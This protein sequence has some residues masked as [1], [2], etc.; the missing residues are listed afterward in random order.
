MH[1]TVEGVSLGCIESARA[2]LAGIALRAPLVRSQDAPAGREIHL[3][4]ENMQPVGSFKLRPIG[5]TVLTK[6]PAALARGIHTASTGNSAVAVAWMAQRLGIPATAVVPENAPQAKL[7]HLRRL[8][9]QI[10]KLPFDDWWRSITSGIHDEAHGLYIDAAREPAALAGNGVIALE[11]LE[12]LADVDAIFVPFG[13][14]ALGC[15]IACATRVLKPGI[16]IIACE[17]ETAQ[18]MTAAMQAGRPVTVPYDSG[19]VS[20]VGFGTILPE[21]WPL[22]SRLIDHTITVT[23]AEV[24]AAVKTMAERNKTIAE[25]AG[26]IPVA[27]ALSGRHEYRKV[28]AVV[29]GGNIDDELLIR[30]LRG[31]AFSR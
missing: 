9:A 8:G 28:C 31:D 20:G 16:R 18:P 23:L 25:G 6:T 13:S 10:V 14:G 27:A 29:S 26:A 2:R 15:G 4:L 24:A 19:F 12:D 30:I 21:M 11:I 1:D 7:D 17:L 22:A 3:K 5:N